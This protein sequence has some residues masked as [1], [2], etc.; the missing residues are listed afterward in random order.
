MNA[1]LCETEGSGT[2]DPFIA[3][4][5]DA[6]RILPVVEA[7]CFSMLPNS[8]TAEV[9]ATGHI[10]SWAGLTIASSTTA[11]MGRTALAGKGAILK[12]VAR[13]ARSLAAFSSSS[14][15]ANFSI[16]LLPGICFRVRTCFAVEENAVASLANESSSCSE[17]TEDSSWEEAQRRGKVIVVELEEI[18]T[19]DGPT[20]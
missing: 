2:W 17:L 8:A 3:T 14:S 13:S 18:A 16:V 20:Q 11:G 12:I 6:V 19:P 10:V 5:L 1:A 7:C 4:L 9:L 15:A